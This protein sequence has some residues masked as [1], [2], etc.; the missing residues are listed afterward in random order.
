MADYPLH[1][2]MMNSSTSIEFDSEPQLKRARLHF[3]V[4]ETCIEKNVD[5]HKNGERNN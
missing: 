1:R 3:E 2:T 4:N 5:L